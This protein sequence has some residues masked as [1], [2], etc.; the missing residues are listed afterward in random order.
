MT[1]IWLWYRIFHRC[2]CLH[3]LFEASVDG[4][5]KITSHA[6]L[7]AKWWIA[8]YVI[9]TF[10]HM[11]TCG[12]LR[13]NNQNHHA[14]HSNRLSYFVHKTLELRDMWVI[15]W[16]CARLKRIN[17]VWHDVESRNSSS[18]KRVVTLLSICGPRVPFKVYTTA[19]HHFNNFL[20]WSW[21]FLA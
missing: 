21:F 18:P 1:V 11:C 2:M 14:V 20:S 8:S 6:I 17:W 5:A 12:I 16:L 19:W 15:K 4:C 13:I 7:L 3:V 10:I 9:L